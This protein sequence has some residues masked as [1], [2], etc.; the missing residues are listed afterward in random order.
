MKTKASTDREAKF[1]RIG[2][3]LVFTTKG[4]AS[5]KN[6]VVER[7]LE[8]S[9]GE[10]DDVCAVPVVQSTDPSQSIR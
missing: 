4:G 10:R 7:I 2:K 6:E 8:D 3:A 9:R 5:L 1:V